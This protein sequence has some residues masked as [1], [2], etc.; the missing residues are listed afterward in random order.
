MTK[1][2]ETALDVYVVFGKTRGSSV[3]GLFL[4]K[5]VY[6]EVCLIMYYAHPH[7]SCALLR[8]CTCTLIRGAAVRLQPGEA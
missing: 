7:A 2:L 5:V 1:I 3:A 6:R 4:V 8:L